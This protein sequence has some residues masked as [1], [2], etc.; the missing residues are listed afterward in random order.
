MPTN[1]KRNSRDKRTKRKSSIKQIWEKL[2]QKN[3]S[4]SILKDTWKSD[5]SN[6]DLKQRIKKYYEKL[7]Q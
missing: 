1:K 4:R 6:L 3:D 7:K 5:P 2:V